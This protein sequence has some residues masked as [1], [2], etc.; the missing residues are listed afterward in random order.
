MTMI[1]RLPVA[2]KTII[3]ASFW[4][5]DSKT[6]SI[7]PWRNLLC[8]HMLSLFLSISGCWHYDIINMIGMLCRWVVCQLCQK[9]FKGKTN[10]IFCNMGLANL[11]QC[12]LIFQCTLYSAIQYGFIVVFEHDTRRLK[13]LFCF[14]ARKK[15][16]QRLSSCSGLLFV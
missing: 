8:L 15:L 10:I 1:I 9:F 7:T 2:D 6:Y 3:V 12:I 4:F 5:I 14:V 13:I 16:H 11:V